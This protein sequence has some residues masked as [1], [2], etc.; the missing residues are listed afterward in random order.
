MAAL[1]NQHIKP[2]SE[3]RKERKKKK[4]KKSFLGNKYF[5]FLNFFP[6]PFFWSVSELVLEHAK[7]TSCERTH[8]RTHACWE[9]KWNDPTSSYKKAT[10]NNKL[11]M[12]VHTYVLQ[13][14][15]FQK[16][17]LFV[18]YC[19]VRAWATNFVVL[20]LFSCRAVELQ[21]LPSWIYRRGKKR[22][23]RRQKGK[24]VRKYKKKKT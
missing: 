14:V 3:E 23:E 1:K 22:G 12:H 5:Y 8:V 24:L 15:S 13:H 11:A 21:I 6:L 19:C 17:L 4:E 10:E 20:W 9:R 2:G 18:L 16:L 7:K